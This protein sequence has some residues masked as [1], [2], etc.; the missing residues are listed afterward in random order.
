MIIGIDPFCFIQD[1]KIKNCEEH[2]FAIGGGGILFL[3]PGTGT[4]ALTTLGMTGGF[5]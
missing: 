2:H 5:V 1:Y 3:A 4:G